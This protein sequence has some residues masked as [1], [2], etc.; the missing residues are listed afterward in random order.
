VEWV[1]ANAEMESFLSCDLDEVLVCA[2]TGGLKSFGAHLLVLVG[3][4]MDTERE[5]IDV[6]ALTAKVEDSDLR[7]RYT[8]V[9]ARL[10]VWLAGR[11]LVLC[12][13]SISSSICTHFLQ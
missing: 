5:L 6:R 9:E 1:R 3:N 11:L 2:N 8:T 7:I 10:W 12:S 13:D 4:E